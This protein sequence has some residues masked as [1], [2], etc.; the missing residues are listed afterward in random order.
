MV[1]VGLPT[2]RTQ[3]E[4]TAQP[5]GSDRNYTTPHANKTINTLQQLEKEHARTTRILRTHRHDPQPPRILTQN[6]SKSGRSTSRMLEGPS[7]TIFPCE[8]HSGK[9]PQCSPS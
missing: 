3:R 9:P 8:C 6:V 4:D 7:P 5:Y 1:T 2:A